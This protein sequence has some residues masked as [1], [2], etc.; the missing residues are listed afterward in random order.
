MDLKPRLKDLLKKKESQNPQS[1]EPVTGTPDPQQPI[2]KQQEGE[3]QSTQ[4]GEIQPPLEEPQPT[5]LKKEEIENYQETVSRLQDNGVFRYN[6]LSKITEHDKL[7][8]EL[9]RALVTQLDTLNR[10]LDRF[11]TLEE[12]GTTEEP[13]EEDT[14]EKP[15]EK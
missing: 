4:P 15:D 12:E 2:Q 11:I 6:L 7:I 14:P 13:G 5:D 10:K 9:G 1:Q 8:T 3:V